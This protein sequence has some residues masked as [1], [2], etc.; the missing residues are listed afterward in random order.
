MVRMEGELEIVA[1]AAA[2]D[3]DAF[4][5]LVERHGR[6]VFTLA[7][8][9]TGNH[10]TAEDVVQ[11]TFMRAYKA[12]HRFDGRAR[13]ST[14]VHRIAVNAALD[15]TRQR[16]VRA[17]VAYESEEILDPAPS[18]APG[19]E[20]LAGSADVRRVLAKAM[21]GL[22]PLERTAFVLRHHEGRTTEEIGEQL[23]LEAGATR[24]AVFRAVR[25]LRE[26]LAPL[27]GETS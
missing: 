1:K 19:P 4:R 13:F 27:V 5:G 12:L 9:I 15:V 20:R 22:S 6:G 14:W 23:G 3:E 17:E 7:Y 21:T 18:P 16:K 8:R 24:Q 2:G 25:K 11:E 26:A 10:S